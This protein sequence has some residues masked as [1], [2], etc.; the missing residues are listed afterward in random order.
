MIRRF[1]PHRIRPVIFNGTYDEHNWK[2]LQERWDDLRAQLHGE[3]IPAQLRAGEDSEGRMILE[4]IA[5]SR[6]EFSPLKREHGD[7]R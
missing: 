4:Q 7:P 5:Q 1:A 2:V 3:A 6:P